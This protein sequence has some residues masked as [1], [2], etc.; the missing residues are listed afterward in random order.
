ML[1]KDSN[2]QTVFLLAVL[3]AP[4]SITGDNLGRLYVANGV[5]PTAVGIQMLTAIAGPSSSPTQVPSEAP[6][7]APSI[8][9]TK[10]PTVV[11]TMVPTDVA[12]ATA[13]E[14]TKPVNVTTHTIEWNKEGDWTQK[15]VTVV[16]Q[17][18]N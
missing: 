18:Q 10:V 3:T 9:P 6:S 14:E 8:V 11:P 15:L 17:Q 16:V 2:Y 1:A 5:G 4:F 7:S 12:V 13:C